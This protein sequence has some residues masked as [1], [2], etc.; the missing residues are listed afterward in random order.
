MSGLVDKGGALASS[1]A[2]QGMRLVRVADFSAPLSL[3]DADRP[4]YVRRFVTLFVSQGQGHRGGTGRVEHARNA[5]GEHLALKLLS[6]PHRRDGETEDDYERRVRASRAAFE[7]EYECHILLSGLKGFPRLYGRGTVDGVPCIVMEWVE[8]ITLDRVRRQLAVDGYGRMSPLVAARLGRDLFDLVARMGYVEGGFVHRDIGPRN[9]MVRTSRLSLEQQVDEGVFDLYLIDFGSSAESEPRSTSFTSENAVFRGATAD[10][11][12]PEMLSDDI[13]GLAELRKSPAIDVYAAASVVY[14]LACGQAPYDLHAVGE[15]GAPVSP[16]R[17]KMAAPA[18]AAVMAHACADELLEALAREPEVAVAVQHAQDKLSAP[19]GVSEAAEALSFVDEQL[20][21]VL[22]D[23]LARG[24]SD[25]PDAAAVLAG[26]A[27]S[28]A[29]LANGAQ[30]SLDAAGF[31]WSGGVPGVV[32]AV[33]ALFP[34]LAGLSLRFGGSRTTAGFLRGTAGL[35][36]TF[37]ALWQVLADMRFEA[38]VQQHLLSM[39]LV[40][41]VAAGWCI[42]VADFALNV[43]LPQMI[44]RKALPS[45]DCDGA[46]ALPGAVALAFEG[47]AGEGEARQVCGAD[48][49]SEYEVDDL[50]DEVSGANA[51]FAGKRDA[52]DDDMSEGA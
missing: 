10:F 52:L 33:A 42:M 14:Q 41:A 22:G 45:G 44:R 9:V 4:S 30:A 16:Y 47:N 49:P 36:V 8:G 13:P 38:A 32:V 46:D 39:A 48:L 50:A 25:R 29:V 20:G 34:A 35:A 23:C 2:V 5:Q 1:G 27:V 17:A 26:V 18:P 11:A 28:A 15:D 12:P 51:R 7:R 3:S 31:A 40:A 19:M 21:I 43:A 6:L 24:Q 37:A